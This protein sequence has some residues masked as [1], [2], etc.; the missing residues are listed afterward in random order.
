MTYLALGA[1]PAKL[2]V[3]AKGTVMPSEVPITASSIVCSEGW[4]LDS[5]DDGSEGPTEGDWDKENLSTE[6]CDSSS[7]T[8]AWTFSVLWVVVDLKDGFDV[9]PKGRCQ[10]GKKAMYSDRPEDHAGC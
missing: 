8:L 6:L 1:I 4:N 5:H 9:F 10:N 7:T 3:K 2:A